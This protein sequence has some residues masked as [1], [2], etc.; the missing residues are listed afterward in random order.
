MGHGYDPFFIDAYCAGMD[1]SFA[2]KSTFCWFH[3]KL[4][5]LWLRQRKAQ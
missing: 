2:I 5:M 3:I 4:M 1:A